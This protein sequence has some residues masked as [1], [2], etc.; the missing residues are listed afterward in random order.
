MKTLVQLSN[1]YNLDDLTV[2]ETAKKHLLHEQY[3]VTGRI[4]KNLSELCEKVLDEC[5][6]KF[7]DLII[8]S[9]YRCRTLNTWVK[10]KSNSQHM[11]GQAADIWAK[12][13]DGLWELIRQLNIDQAIRYKTFI[14]VSYAGIYNRHQ[15]INMIEQKR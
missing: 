10:G 9:G 7:P 4:V 5:K 1:Q 11:D 8:T 3:I 14:H 6:V 15:Y 12:N 2:S 13:I